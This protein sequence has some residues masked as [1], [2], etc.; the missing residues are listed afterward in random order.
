MSDVTELV[1]VIHA[2]PG[3]II[4]DKNEQTAQVVE[5]FEG[6]YGDT[7]ESKEVNDGDFLTSESAKERTGPDGSESVVAGVSIPNLVTCSINMINVG[8]L[9]G[10]KREYTDSIIREEADSDYS[11]SSEESIEEMGERRNWTSERLE[12]YWTQKKA[13]IC[14]SPIDLKV[15]SVIESWV[16]E[17]KGPHV[18]LS[19][20]QMRLP[21]GL[22][23]E[24]EETPLVCGVS[25]VDP[26]TEPRYEVERIVDEKRTKS[27]KKKYRVRW[28]GYDESQDTW[29]TEELLA[30]D[31][32]R[33][34]STWKSRDKRRGK[35][36]K[37]KLKSKVRL[38]IVSNQSNPEAEHLP[39][40]ESVPGDV[41]VCRQ[42]KRNL[43]TATAQCREL[44][45]VLC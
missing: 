28:E 19:W 10:K 1:V 41:G 36:T 33:V 43:R 9:S 15:C 12:A 32:P 24:R 11:I 4:A 30:K 31:C 34:L 2:A 25:I 16:S 42:S 45:K 26:A 44:S 8:E 27:K 3:L 37:D 18:D 38:E 40:F 23:R 6:G 22:N 29:E 13:K 39:A 20:I 5:N 35:P 17:L 21:E 7:P 14:P